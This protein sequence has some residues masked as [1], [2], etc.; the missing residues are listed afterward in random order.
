MNEAKDA[1]KAAIP[2]NFAVK[3]TLDQLVVERIAWENR[4]NQQLYQLLD[5]CLLLMTEVTGN[6]DQSTAVETFIKD[7]G[8][9][10]RA[11]T[12]LETKIVRAVFG[13]CGSRE[14]AYSRI[15]AVAKDAKPDGQSMADWIEACG[16]VEKIRRSSGNTIEGKITQPAV[17]DSN[18][19]KTS[20]LVIEESQLFADLFEEDDDYKLLVLRRLPGKKVEVA[21]QTSDGRKLSS[22]IQ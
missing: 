2:A 1:Q 13:D 8:L 20:A 10:V 7:Q 12:S 6:S 5:R 15:L 19:V 22:F 18:T 3:A 4:S 14:F 16:G 21:Y 17:S 9:P 11:N